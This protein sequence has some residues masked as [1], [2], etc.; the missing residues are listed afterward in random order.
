MATVDQRLEG[1]H[2]ISADRHAFDFQAEL[3]FGEFAGGVVVLEGDLG[4]GDTQVLGLHVEPRQRNEL[5][6]LL[7]EISDRYGYDLAGSR[8]SAD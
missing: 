2:R 8:R 4:P 3:L 7:P 1:R 5:L 6:H